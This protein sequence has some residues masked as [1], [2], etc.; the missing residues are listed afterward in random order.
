MTSEKYNIQKNNFFIYFQ[1]IREIK[2]CL[3]YQEEIQSKVGFGFS[4]TQKNS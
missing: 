2:T 4:S 1:V 3:E